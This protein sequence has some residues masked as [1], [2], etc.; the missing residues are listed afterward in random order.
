MAS[1]TACIAGIAA[2]PRGHDNHLMPFL[3]LPILKPVNVPYFVSIETMRRES[4]DKKEDE[5]CIVSTISAQI[6][7]NV[8]ENDGKITN[9]R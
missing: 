2:S 5:D 4:N 1:H 6:T 3:V 7:Y 9:L 8:I